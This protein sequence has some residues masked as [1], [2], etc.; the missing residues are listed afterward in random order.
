MIH[1]FLVVL[2]VGNVFSQE[3]KTTSSDTR[4]F[5]FEADVSSMMKILINSLYSNKEIFLRELIS[6]CADAMNKVKLDAIDHPEIMG[7]PALRKL[8]IT[9]VPDEDQDTISII[10]RGVGMTREELM[11]NLGTVAQSGTMKFLQA[12]EQSGSSQDIIGQF[13]V[14]FYS[15]FLVA[16]KIEVTSKTFGS[17]KQY[18]WSSSG[19]HGFTI[20]EDLSGNDLVRGTN[21]TL[22]LNDP[23]Y[24]NTSIVRGVIQK[25]SQF[26]DF[27]IYLRVEQEEKN[28]RRRDDDEDDDEDM[29]LDY[30]EPTYD[31][32][33]VNFQKALWLREPDSA[34]DEEYI[35]F[36][37]NICPELKEDPRI[38]V[39]F[40]QKVDC[41]FKAILYIPGA[42]PKN[43][44][45]L[46]QDKRMTKLKL[47][48]KRILITEEFEDFLPRY[49][50]F[51]RGVVDSDDLSLNVS[52]EMLQESKDLRMMARKI[53]RKA[54]QMMNEIAER[55][56]EEELE[57]EEN[58]DDDDEEEKE[59][60]YMSFY[61]DFGQQVKLGVIEDKENRK[62]LSKLLRFNTTFSEDHSISLDEYVANM[63]PD[64][65]KI[66]FLAGDP[67]VTTIQHSPFL[68]PFRK[69]NW[70]V[71]FF[72]DPLDEIAAA[73]IRTYEGYPLESI[74]G[75]DKNKANTQKEK[76]RLRVWR[77]E[78]KP[79]ISFFKTLLKGNVTRV[80]ISTRLAVDTKSPCVLA[81]LEGTATAQME[82]ISRQQA[83]A[84]PEA[85]VYQ[86]K[87]V[88]EINPRSD[89]IQRL[90][91]AIKQLVEKEKEKVTDGTP[92]EAKKRTNQLKKD[93]TKLEKIG[94]ML[95]ETAMLDGGYPIHDTTL[96]A[97]HVFEVMTTMTGL[98]H[99]PVM[100][101]DVMFDFAEFAKREEQEEQEAILQQDRE[102]RRKEEKAKELLS[103]DPTVE[104]KVEERDFNKNEEAFAPDEKYLQEL[105]V[106]D[107]EDQRQ[108][109]LQKRKEEREKKR[110]QMEKS[111]QRQ[112][113]AKQKK[114]GYYEA[115]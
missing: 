98:P 73:S 67:T 31:Y 23:Q 64:Q 20:E 45:G 95:F 53:I 62:R 24:A 1:P 5:D 96:Y 68:I 71:L 34:S 115:D 38:W 81:N 36:Y 22:F 15:A 26:V 70:D 92:E 90:N 58:G 110:K 102:R 78:Y 39:H 18:R 69:K 105:H 29:E 19:T 41:T 75:S 61:S 12:A 52:R 93:R 57:A 65:K 46:Q 114:D 111:K 59:S 54:I 63:K 74:T 43:E 3:T 2:F 89:L 30:V 84:N 33:H 10:D 55:S 40:H 21:V 87:K 99:A 7:T 79:T 101:D 6:N 109:E 17:D 85:G 13:G 50:S 44:K 32:E 97:D 14:G 108:K 80:E 86:S 11:T 9:I 91:T 82:Q 8:D 107:P 25:Y 48:I 47:Y 103:K 35:D 66:Y 51:L 28:N 27:P 37:H 106:E 16:D 49:L 83:A 104:T 4:H 113:R 56:R 76:D 72:P 94:Q 88:L 112:E 77:T 42:R 60:R 100:P